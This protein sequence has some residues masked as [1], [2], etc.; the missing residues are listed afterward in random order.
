MDKI[1]TNKCLFLRG[2][3]LQ[4]LEDKVNK[5]LR[6]DER[7]QLLSLRQDNFDRYVATLVYYS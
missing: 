6:E 2:D 5:Y 4:E 7:W 3:V 1:Y